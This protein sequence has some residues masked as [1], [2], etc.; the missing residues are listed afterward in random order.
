MI[1]A[2]RV[3]AAISALRAAKRGRMSSAVN[4]FLKQHKR[5]G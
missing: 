4:E 5:P 2:G 3:N 1:R